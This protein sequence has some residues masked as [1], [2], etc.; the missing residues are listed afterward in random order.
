MGFS[1]SSLNESASTECSDIIESCVESNNMAQ[2]SV[3]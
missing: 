2:E 3:N 1:G